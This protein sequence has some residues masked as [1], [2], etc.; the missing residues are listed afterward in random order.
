MPPPRRATNRNAVQQTPSCM[1]GRP[2]WR[3]AAV[4][5]GDHKLYELLSYNHQIAL[6]LLGE[7]EKARACSGAGARPRRYG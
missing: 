4:A 6:Q 1:W 2:P 5:A 3:Q 7:T